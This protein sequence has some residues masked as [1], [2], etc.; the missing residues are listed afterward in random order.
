MK[1]KDVKPQS[2]TLKKVKRL[3][4]CERKKT[5]E[6][7]QMFKRTVQPVL[8]VN[9]RPKAGQWAF[10]KFTALVCDVWCHGTCSVS[11]WTSSIIGLACFR[12]WYIILHINNERKDSCILRLKFCFYYTDYYR[13]EHK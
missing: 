5:M 6:N 10:F 12:N 9:E 1:C 8:D 7:D 11:H 13:F 3:F 2:L 4:L